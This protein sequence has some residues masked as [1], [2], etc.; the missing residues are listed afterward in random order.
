MYVRQQPRETVHHFWARFLL[1]KNKIKD[2]CDDDAVPVFHRN[3]TDEGI[4]NALDHRCI[5]SFTELSHVVWKYC[6]MESM[7]KAQKTQLEPAAFRQ[8]T[9]R[10]KG[11]HP[12]EASDH[13]PVGN[14]NKPFSVYMSILD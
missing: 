14:K 7:W 1:V 9:A 2:C 3:C 4:R 6:A 8:C 13:K 11:M 5:Q 12:H 10:A